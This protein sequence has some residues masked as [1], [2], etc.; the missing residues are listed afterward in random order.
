M[1]EA[2][3][4]TDTTEVLTQFWQELLDVDI[5]RPGDHLLECGGNS[6]VATMLA[7]RIELIWGFRPTMAELM[8]S[9]FSELSALC[10]QS[11]T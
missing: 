8:T 11:R 4:G 6:L 10:D 1:S 7:N 3:T 9:S 2:I 5:V